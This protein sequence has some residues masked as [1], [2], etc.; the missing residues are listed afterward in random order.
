MG[1]K[2]CGAR[3]LLQ[4]NSRNHGLIDILDSRTQRGTYRPAWRL[5]ALGVNIPIGQ[6]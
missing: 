3:K 2:Y 6:C 4:A 1:M 5:E